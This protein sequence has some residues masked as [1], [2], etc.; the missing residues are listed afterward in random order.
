T[1]H[2]P[3]EVPART[4]D[5]DIAVTEHAEMATEARPTRRVRDH[6]SG[7]GEYLEP[8]LRQ[9]FPPDRLRGRAHDH[10]DVRMDAPVLQQLRRD[11][12]VFRT[13][14]GAGPEERLLH[15]DVPL[16][17]LARRVNVGRIV[18]AGH[19]WL[20]DLEI[21]VDPLRVLTPSIGAH[22]LVWRRRAASQ[23]RAESLVVFAD[24]RLRAH[25]DAHVAEAPAALHDHIAQS[26][27]PELQALVDGEA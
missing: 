16:L 7:L 8:P 6:G 2:A 23:I 11:L 14:I 3:F 20:D 21:D 1:A 18:W 4:R 15:A 24:G 12:E 19:Q 13:P 26:W 5:A 10:P 17:H 9:R 27:A 22:R 25:L